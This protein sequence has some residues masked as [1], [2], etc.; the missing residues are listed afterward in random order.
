MS[1]IQKIQFHLEETQEN[2][3]TELEKKFLVV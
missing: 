3:V 2:Y 1:E